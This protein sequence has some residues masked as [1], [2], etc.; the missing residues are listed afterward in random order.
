MHVIRLRQ[1][2]QRQDLPGKVCWRRAFHRPTGLDA[3]ER[4]WL[5]VDRPLSGATVRLNGQPL[6][7]V[8]QGTVGRLDVTDLLADRNALEIDVAL[9]APDE[10]GELAG[11]VRLEIEEG[12]GDRG[13]RTGKE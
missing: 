8:E 1:P 6:G 7:D 11:D 12:T 5:V 3:G 10:A 4:V 13:Q 9:A 2:W